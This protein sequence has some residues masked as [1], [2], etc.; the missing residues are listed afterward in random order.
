MVEV[1]EGNPSRFFYE[2]MGARMI[3]LQC[4]RF[5]GRDLPTYVYAWSDIR[6]LA[7]AI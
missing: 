4:Q 1:L 5:A 3:A 2:A 7:G 6:A